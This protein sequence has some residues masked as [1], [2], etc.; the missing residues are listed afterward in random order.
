MKRKSYTKEFKTK[1]AI[2]AIKGQR[3]VNE[4]AS[5][6][7]RLALEAG[8]VQLA[9][10]LLALA[11]DHSSPDWRIVSG[12]GAALAK[13]GKYKQAIPLFER[14]HTLAPSNS[15]VLNNLAMAHAGSVV[16]PK[17]TTT[18]AVRARLRSAR[19][20]DTPKRFSPRTATSSVSPSVPTC[21]AA[22]STSLGRVNAPRYSAG[23]L[24]RPGA[25]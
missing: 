23:I 3:T 8:Q 2:E 9:S 1:V 6:Y 4:I 18:S 16:D 15:T 20:V 19:R 5:E 17:A 7:G 10:K 21:R 22:T 12:R 25:L 11:D 13:Q 14:A 24:S